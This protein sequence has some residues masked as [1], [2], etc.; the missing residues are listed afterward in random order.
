MDRD[1][2]LTNWHEPQPLAPSNLSAP[3]RKVEKQ[4]DEQSNSKPNFFDSVVDFIPPLENSNLSS[5]QPNPGDANINHKEHDELQKLRPSASSLK[6]NNL[7]LNSNLPPFQNE[8]NVVYA[9]DTN[10][11]LDSNGK[12]KHLEEIQDGDDF[13]V[14]TQEPEK[15]KTEEAVYI[16]NHKLKTISSINDVLSNHTT[17]NNSNNSATNSFNISNGNKNEESEEFTIQEMKEVRARTL[18][19]NTKQNTNIFY[20]VF[21]QKNQFMDKIQLPPELS[22]IRDPDISQRFWEAAR[23]FKHLGDTAFKDWKQLKKEDSNVLAKEN[24]IIDKYWNAATKFLEWAA[25]V[26]NC[27]VSFLSLIWPLFFKS[28]KQSKNDAQFLLGVANFWGYVGEVFGKKLYFKDRLYGTLL[29][30][31]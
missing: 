19:S 11:P 7:E 9:F 30:L 18:E 25:E 3:R 2:K 20:Y 4:K 15:S 10:E 14:S 29:P 16:T 6:S 24:E 26:C 22:P 27:R 23:T 12:D 8:T 28:Q 1:K 31:W 21:F 5:S 13:I 17:G